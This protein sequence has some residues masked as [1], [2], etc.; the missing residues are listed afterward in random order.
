MIS[1]DVRVERAHVLEDLD[2]L[3]M[4]GSG[5]PGDQSEIGYSWI[6]PTVSHEL[7]E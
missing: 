6:I 5:V 2:Q 3:E 7:F 1:A 4:I